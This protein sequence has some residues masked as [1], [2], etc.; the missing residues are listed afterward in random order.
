M[1]QQ[2]NRLVVDPVCRSV[3]YHI[4]WNILLDRREEKKEERL[5][6]DQIDI[7]TLQIIASIRI[8]LIIFILIAPSILI[9]TF[10]YF[11]KYNS[12]C[13]FY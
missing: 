10:T 6:V 1:L 2:M 11:Y 8:E 12:L 13:Y 3:T 4:L 7:T 9:L 5:I